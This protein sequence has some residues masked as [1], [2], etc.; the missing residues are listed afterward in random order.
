MP[1]ATMSWEQGR[2]IVAGHASA[3][4]N[5]AATSNKA[6]LKLADD[7][8]G[9]LGIS[10]GPVTP[11]QVKEASKLVEP[12]AE[13][14]ASG[15]HRRAGGMGLAP[16]AHAEIVFIATAGRTTHAG[17]CDVAELRKAN[18]LLRKSR[19]VRALKPSWLRLPTFVELSR[20]QRS[21]GSI[22]EH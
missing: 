17:E 4:K 8:F 9:Q 10:V 22:Y 19:T 13:G 6:A 5:P 7:A 18:A 16:A 11:L 15:F 12:P 3:M 21:E 2:H 14:D 20:E 1:G